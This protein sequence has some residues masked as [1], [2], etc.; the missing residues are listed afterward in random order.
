MKQI[1]YRQI[2][3]LKTKV[4]DFNQKTIFK[5]NFMHFYLI[6][7]FITNRSV[8]VYL[9]TMI[10]YGISKSVRLVILLDFSSEEKKKSNFAENYLRNIRLVQID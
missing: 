2:S 6:V 4:N 8:P 5:E 3:I 1:F 7:D 9:S 10:F